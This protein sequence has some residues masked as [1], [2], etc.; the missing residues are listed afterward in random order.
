ML[1]SLNHFDYQLTTK[2]AVKRTQLAKLNAYLAFPSPKLCVIHSRSHR[3]WTVESKKL[4][5]LFRRVNV[6]HLV[7]QFITSPTQRYNLCKG[8]GNMLDKPFGSSCMW[9]DLQ[10]DYDRKMLNLIKFFPFLKLNTFFRLN[11]IT[12]VDSEEI[13][14]L[15]LIVLI[16]CDWK[17]RCW[18]LNPFP[19]IDTDCMWLLI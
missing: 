3:V 2:F 9:S 5:P 19:S 7:K 15:N 4:L 8:L 1:H 14:S 11:V 6:R 16:E 18:I 10:L 17:M 12:L 13:I